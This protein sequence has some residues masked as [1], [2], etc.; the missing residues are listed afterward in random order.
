MAWDK[1]RTA[2]R[3]AIE[4][5]DAAYI[6]YLG[7]T[8]EARKAGL[9]EVASPSIGD[10]FKLLREAVLTIGRSSACEITVA[11]TQLSQAH[12]IVAVLPTGGLA[13]IDLGS[14]NGCWVNGRARTVHELQLGDEF[15]LA[16]AFRFRCQPTA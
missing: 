15:E 6:I 1:R 8:E 7:L 3:S 2:R 14:R 11:L 16:R 5:R 10:R 13:L 9:D 4:I 12:A